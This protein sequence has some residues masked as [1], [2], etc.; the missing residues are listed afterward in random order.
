MQSLLNFWNLLFWLI[1]VSFAL[2]SSN[3]TKL[4]FI[5]ELV[6][7]ILYCYVIVIGSI[8]D[9]ISI[10]STCFFILGFAGLEFSIGM[11]LVIIL[12]KILKV[13]YFYESNNVQNNNMYLT[14]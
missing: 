8:N 9:E 3:F 10:M 13:D 14:N 7:I 4:L 6:W 5:S 2:N 12:K 1:F 11:L